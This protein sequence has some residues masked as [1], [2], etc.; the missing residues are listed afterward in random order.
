MST[1]T[2]FKENKNIFINQLDP[3]INE[4]VLF[5]RIND[6]LQREAVF[7]V[8]ISRDTTR[9]ETSIAHVQMKTH[10]DAAEA[11]QKLN[12][13]IIEGKKV[14]ISWSMKDYKQRTQIETNLYVKGIKK[15]IKV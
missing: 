8:L 1:I 3:K 14:N 4:S 12:G 13:K 2:E 15:E 6:E 11:I 7:K 9:Y 5:K 10:E